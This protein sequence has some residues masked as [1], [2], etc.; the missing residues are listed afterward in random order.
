MLFAPPA[1]SRAARF[2]NGAI[3][4]RQAPPSAN[5]STRFSC[6]RHPCRKPFQLAPGM[7]GPDTVHACACAGALPCL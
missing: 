5:R 2:F 3:H 7:Y 4:M 1:K 6:S